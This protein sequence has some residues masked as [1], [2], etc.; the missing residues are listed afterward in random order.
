V[1]T[2]FRTFSLELSC[3]GDKRLIHLL[4]LCSYLRFFPLK[5]QSLYVSKFLS[6]IKSVLLL[7]F[8]TFSNAKAT[9]GHL[10]SGSTA[11]SPPH[12]QVRPLS[13]ANCS[14]SPRS[15]INET[16]EIPRNDNPCAPFLPLLIIRTPHLTIY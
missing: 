10:S 13:S 7:L 3:R 8:D 16:E 12:H 5:I 9:H 6:L 14:P 4:W 1:S 15:L 11:S 2:T